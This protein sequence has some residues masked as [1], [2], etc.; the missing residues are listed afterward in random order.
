MKKFLYETHC[1][2]QIS[3]ACAVSSAVELVDTYLKNGY[4]G[5]FITDHFING[6]ARVRWE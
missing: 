2:T 1:H 5:I 3:S 6:N 4:T